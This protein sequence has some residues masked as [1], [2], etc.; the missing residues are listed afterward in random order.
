MKTADEPPSDHAPMK[1]LEA[2]RYRR[3][4][5]REVVVVTAEVQFNPTTSKQVTRSHQ[6]LNPAARAGLIYDVTS[7]DLST[8]LR[9]FHMLGISQE[10]EQNGVIPNHL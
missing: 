8:F 3:V 4:V 6:T 9:G 5:I 7:A 10:Y 1:H 2:A